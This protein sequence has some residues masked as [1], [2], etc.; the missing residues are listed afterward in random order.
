MLSSTDSVGT[1]P[2]AAPV[3]AV[4]VAVLKP[5]TM[6]G[7]T[8]VIMNEPRSAQISCIT[9]VRFFVIASISV[10]FASTCTS[11]ILSCMTTRMGTCWFAFAGGGV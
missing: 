1:D 3:S 11:N 8:G 2:L 5:G 7:E 6:F 4:Q 9:D 10:I